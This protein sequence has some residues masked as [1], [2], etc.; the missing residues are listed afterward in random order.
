MRGARERARKR[1]KPD[2]LGDREKRCDLC[3]VSP[4]CQLNPPSFS[5]F[6]TVSTFLH[7]H[8]DVAWVVPQVEVDDV[9]PGVVEHGLGV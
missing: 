9:A 5:G 2:Y 4:G 8:L 1:D 3:R 7:V 6:I